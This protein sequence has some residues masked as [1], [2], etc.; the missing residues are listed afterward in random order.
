MAGRFRRDQFIGDLG[1]EW[2][3]QIEI[4]HEERQM[5]VVRDSV[6]RIYFERKMAPVLEKLPHRRQRQF[7]VTELSHE[8]AFVNLFMGVLVKRFV[9]IVDVFFGL[10]LA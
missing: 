4:A 6:E 5:S 7:A 9:Q 10:L 8:R 3:E 2:A 1:A